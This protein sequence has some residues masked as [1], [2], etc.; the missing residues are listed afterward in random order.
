MSLK[1]YLQKDIDLLCSHIN[2]LYRESLG[3]KCPFDLVEQY[4]PKEILN[5]LNIKKIDD[6]KVILTPKLLGTKNIENIKKYLDYKEIKEAHI[7]L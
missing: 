6:D 5:K 2:S 3:G 7:S 1:N 4:I